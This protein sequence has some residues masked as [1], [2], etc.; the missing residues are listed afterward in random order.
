MKRGNYYL[1]RK[2]RLLR[3][4]DRFST[5][6][7]EVL[8]CEYGDEDAEEVTQEIRR[9][10]ESLIPQI[11]YIGGK[12]N[13]LTEN[14]IGTTASLALFKV[15]RAR[16]ETTERI[17]GLLGRDRSFVVSLCEETSRFGC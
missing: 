15:L 11:P 8:A 6:V 16:G 3:D 10:Y 9:Q 2:T 17:V 4:F 5:A 12:K 7:T 13:R 1:A 14:L